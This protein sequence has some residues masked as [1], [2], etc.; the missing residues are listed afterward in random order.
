MKKR[1]SSIPKLEEKLK[2]IMK[3]RHLKTGN[4]DCRLRNFLKINTD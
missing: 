2:A 4:H 3:V 1:P